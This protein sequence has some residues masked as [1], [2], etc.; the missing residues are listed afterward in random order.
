MNPTQQQCAA[1]DSDALDILLSAGAG[2]GKTSTTVRRYE[3]LLTGVYTDGRQGEPVEPDSILVFTFTDKAAGELRDR[4]RRLRDS[5]NLGFSMGSLWVGTFHSICARIL[6]GHPVAAGVDPAFEVIDEVIANRL[7]E[8]SY[9]TAL[10]RAAGPTGAIE[11]L[12]QF[13][14]STLKKGIQAA[15]ERLRAAGESE[16]VLPEPPPGRS[17]ETI[18]R[19]LLR[20]ALS[21][22]A[23]P[24]LKPAP[25]KRANNV[26]EALQNLDP[27]DLD[28]ELLQEIDIY[29]N[30]SVIPVLC[31]KVARAKIEL[32]SREAG[33]RYWEVLSVLL[34]GYGKAYE[35][36]KSRR[37]VLDFEDLQLRTLDLLLSR[38][39]LG[40]S[41][42]EQ[43]A[44]IMV[45]EFQDTNRL[46]MDLIDAL[47]GETTRLFTVGDEMQAIYGFRYADV[48][49][50]RQRRSGIAH[51][52]SRDPE[53]LGT[54]ERDRV[55]FEIELLSLNANFRSD[56]PVI[57]AVNEIGRQ[58]ESLIEDL[59]TDEEP[60][61]AEGGTRH[62]FEE[63]RVGRAPDPDDHASRNPLSPKVEILLT[64]AGS[65][66]ETDLGPLAPRPGEGQY[67]KDGRGEH[68]AEALA[69]AWHIRAAVEEGVAPGDI[70]VLLRTKTRMWLFEE[71]LKQVGLRPYVVGGTG[72]W[73]T[74]EGVDLRALLATLANP[75]ED[76]AL[77]GTIAGPGC[78]LSPSALWLLTRGRNRDT[79]LW[80]R[81]ELL[82][83]EGI[84]GIEPEDRDRAIRFVTTIRDLGNRRAGLSLAE[85]VKAVVSETGYDL[86]NLMR[87]PSGA[88]LA[89]IRRVAEIAGE[90]EAAEGRDLRGLIGWIDD[91]SRLD[92]EQAIATEDEQ[93]D[94]VRLMTIHKSKGLEFPMV[95]VADLGRES[96]A[97]PEDV[98][99]VSPRVEEPGSFDVG[100]RLPEAEGKSLDLYDWAD[101]KSKNRL[102]TTDEELRI[103]HVAMTRA[104]NRLVLSGVADLAEVPGSTEAK[105]FS[106]R[107]TQVFG[108]EHLEDGIAVPPA[109]APETS[110]LE[111]PG[112]QIEVTLVRA[113]DSEGLGK[114]MKPVAAADVRTG[115]GRPPLSRPPSAAFPE[116]PLSYS[117]LASYRDCPTRFFAT[118]V[119][120]LDD[121]EGSD[122]S[123]DDE[124]GEQPLDPDL[125][126]RRPSDGTSFGDAVHELLELL[127]DRRWRPPGEAEIRRALESHGV[128]GSEAATVRTMIEGFTGSDLG[129]RARSSRVEV[130][131]GLLVE[132]GG[133]VIRGFA[134]LLITDPG[135]PLILDYKSNQLAGTSPS[136][137]MEKYD[138]QRDLYALAVSQA[139]GAATV[140]TAFVFLRDPENPVI[141]RFDEDR[142]AATRTSLTG[143]VGEIAR[144]RYLGG[145]DAANQPCGECWACELMARQIE[146]A[147]SPVTV[148]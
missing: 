11:I 143:L 23:D 82:A 92:S 103:L 31:Q 78:G 73:E 51:R 53:R 4:I 125:V 35:E 137:L 15:Y 112:S 22:A 75:R 3:R 49:L 109:E 128:A 79:P 41:Y 81:L 114:A 86:V 56:A 130:E 104:E 43:F 142:L 136:E 8:S 57:G 45:D 47:R 124:T 24:D 144:G 117:A 71:A 48:E 32:L 102:E 94:V 17:L 63:L 74:R 30:S 97:N 6:R 20:E 7:K 44:E 98:I 140:E 1:I 21:T 77:I 18:Q 46:Q 38:P 13:T 90:Y 2:S 60:G 129:S 54:K 123:F 141:E 10:D 52:L 99:W 120:K 69:L 29:A 62:E 85:L 111:F 67:V 72:F 37:G 61:G 80:P 33:P 55:G 19:D 87:D 113:E 139:L 12:S 34:A 108:L 84:D 14:P 101:L 89:N 26:V 91:S 134:D 95:C 119:L 138:L 110:N 68:E 146:A 96:K 40:E 83:D 106:T 39:D 147:G 115:T 36:A 126:E 42:R 145:P 148:S 88:G 76:E 50:F 127:P 5:G 59:R 121:P 27:A 25:R 65:W 28:F 58:F 66:K 118:R 107:L 100:L 122:R 132:I 105:P 131:S 9:S 64:E 133:V 135:I 93:S 116:V 16:P 70:V